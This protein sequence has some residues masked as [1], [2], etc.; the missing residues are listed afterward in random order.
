MLEDEDS[1]TAVILPAKDEPQE[2]A[3]TNQKAIMRTDRLVQSQSILNNL[4]DAYAG[5]DSGNFGR[6]RI[7]DALLMWSPP[8]C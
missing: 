2:I 8:V 1:Q 5:A 6:K 4:R 7:R 3:D